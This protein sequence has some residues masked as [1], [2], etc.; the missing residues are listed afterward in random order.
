MMNRAELRC[1]IVLILEPCGHVP[2]SWLLHH[3]FSP[4]DLRFLESSTH[5]S[6]AL[7]LLPS[8]GSQNLGTLGCPLTGPCNGALQRGALGP[9]A[10]GRRRC[11][12]R[13]GGPGH[14]SE[15][16][17]RDVCSHVLL[18]WCCGVL[19]VFLCALCASCV[20]SVLFLLTCFVILLVVFHQW[21]GER[22]FPRSW[23]FCGLPD[24]DV[25]GVFL[26][27]GCEN[28]SAMVM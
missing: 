10:P 2:T 25:P 20:Y 15:L 26:G 28:N 4:A 8:C 16:P 19:Y 23:R 14:S 22:N 13:Q 11:G 3:A 24:P 9:P 21:F 18:C 1:L 27:G 6:W 7:E 5:G 17:G 12:D